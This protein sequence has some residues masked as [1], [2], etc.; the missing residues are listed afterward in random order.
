[1][2]ATEK[3]RPLV[4]QRYEHERIRQSRDC[5]GAVQNPTVSG[6]NLHFMKLGTSCR[7]LAVAALLWSSAC[8][9]D[10]YETFVGKRGTICGVK[11]IVIKTYA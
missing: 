3:L 2:L 5:Q 8:P 1:M 9:E 10:F 6:A 11:A 7:S 4:S